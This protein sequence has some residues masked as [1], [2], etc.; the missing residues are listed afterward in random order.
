MSVLV[1]ATSFIWEGERDKEE[2]E[3]RQTDGR[4]ERERKKKASE[5]RKVPYCIRVLN[6]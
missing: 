2:R 5:A 1:C 3:R 6:M 4:G